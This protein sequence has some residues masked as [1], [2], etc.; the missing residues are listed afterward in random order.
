MF[1]EVTRHL[2]RQGRPSLG[3]PYE[4]F[5]PRCR[6]RGDD[7]CRCSI[8]CLIPDDKYEERFEN[9]AIDVDLRTGRRSEESRAIC[10]AA[11]ISDEDTLFAKR[12]QRIHDR[13]ATAKD[14]CHPH[15]TPEESWLRGVVCHLVELAGE[16]D[17][18]LEVLVELAA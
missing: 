1:D 8:G 5:A 13:G 3:V 9:V 14:C 15:V 4:N 10:A 12:L 18:D 7:G 16:E 11:G 2:I 6:Y 17:L